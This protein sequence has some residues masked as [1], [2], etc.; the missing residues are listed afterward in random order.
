MKS[1]ITTECV[2]YG[3]P[4]KIADQISDSLLDGYIRKDSTSKVAIET[5]VKDNIV[6]L[7]GEVTSSATIDTD[8]TVREVFSNIIFS[9]EH[10]LKPENI[11]I[12]NLIGKQS[13]EINKG[14]FKE[15]GEIG[16]GDQGIMFGY[17]TNET[18]NYMP[19]GM[20]VA[21]K[22]V[23]MVCD[24]Y[25]NM[26]GPDC[27]SQV[28]IENECNKSRIHTI[29]ISTQ[30]NTNI[31]LDEVK[32]LLVNSIYGN[33]MD[34]SSNIYKLIDCNTIIKINPAGSWNIGGP[35]SDCGMTGRKIVV[36]QYGPYCPVGGGGF[37]GKDYSKTD[38]TAAYSA[39]YI[40]KNI[41]SSGVLDRCTI[42]LSYT[43]GESKP[44]SIRIEGVKNNERIIL[45]EIITAKITSLFPLTPIEISNKFDLK[46]VEYKKLSKYGHFG[47]DYLPWEQ[48]DKVEEIKKIII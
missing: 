33:K 16:S 25:P 5:M 26:L 27:K 39:R 38:R 17:A 37:S 18:D 48:L 9:N 36:D 46:N 47:N 44:T 7:G 34:L 13:P 15:D 30:H 8:K 24:L 28:T 42:E 35:I 22:L 12:I 19:V 43:I 21:R 6:V 40:A 45:D 4:D 41:V 23:N 32:E 3:H 1:F 31:S 2:G 20:Y 10:N 14:V 29:L 11:K